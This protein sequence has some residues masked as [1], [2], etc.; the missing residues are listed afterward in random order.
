[1]D[2]LSK[3]I[4]REMGGRGLHQVAI[5]LE[6]VRTICA[7]DRV[8]PPDPGLLSRNC[9]VTDLPSG[10]VLTAQPAPRLK[11]DIYRIHFPDVKTVARY[12]DCSE[13]VVRYL[14]IKQAARKGG[15]KP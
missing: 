6:E 3:Q 13:R 15:W 1:M 5:S 2:E 10:C 8:S 14:Q 7:M 11:G 4:S 12:A 9:R